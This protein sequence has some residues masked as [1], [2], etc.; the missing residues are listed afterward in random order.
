MNK[1]F[2]TLCLV[3]SFLY[4][5]QAT[6]IELSKHL[7]TIVDP[8][9]IVRVA[10]KYP[11]NTAKSR[12]E[13]WATLSFVIEK[14]G[15]VSNVLVTETSGSKDFAQ[16]SIKAVAKWKYKPAMENGEAIQQCL[17]SVRMDFRMD[18]KGDDGKSGVSR[19]FQK[20]YNLA[21]AALDKKD[22][23]AVEQYINKMFENNRRHLSENNYLHTLAAGYAK[24]IKD[25]EQRLY[26]LESIS[27][28]KSK[29]MTPQRKLAILNARFLLA[30]QLNKFQ[31]AF[32]TYNQLKKLTVA[33]PYLLKYENII[34]KSDAFIGGEKDIV[35]EANIKQ[36]DFWQYALMRNE[37]SL[38]DING[39]LN[40]LDIRCANKR[41]VY[42][43]EN[44]NTWKIPKVWKNCSLYVYGEDDTSFTLTEHPNK[45]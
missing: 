30:I 40:K 38:T 24:A 15:S 16:A 45:S 21:L 20:K 26:H 10:P 19:R 12:R 44:N 6:A 34:A 32:K 28:H 25:P 4:T 23:P 7:T 42:T 8:N 2:L 41:H 31:K 18:K 33:K 11:R 29:D 5:A 22:Y 43:V 35:I 36:Q 3:F 17:N 13:G 9:P 39:S 1:K 27:L 37:F 14:N